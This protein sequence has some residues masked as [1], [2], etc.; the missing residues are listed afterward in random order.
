[1]RQFAICIHDATPAHA[2]VTQMMIETLTPA[3]GKPSADTFARIEPVPADAFTP[4][5]RCS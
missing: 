3:V 2:A 4:F 5:A 1:M